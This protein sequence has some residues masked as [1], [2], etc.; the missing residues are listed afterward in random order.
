MVLLTNSN[1]LI[2]PIPRTLVLHGDERPVGAALKGDTHARALLGDGLDVRELD[3]PLCAELLGAH[4]HDPV[5]RQHNQ[6]VAAG[7]LQVRDVVFVEIFPVVGGLEPELAQGL[8]LRVRPHDAVHADEAGETD[9][10]QTLW[11]EDRSGVPDTF[12]KAC[13]WWSDQ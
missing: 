10:L 13:R 5:V 1:L 11:V 6:H 8:A 7:E 4:E 2:Q 3:V 12:S 9:A